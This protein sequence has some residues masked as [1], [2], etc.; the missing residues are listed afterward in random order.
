MHFP[1]GT[2]YS[3]ALSPDIASDRVNAFGDTIFLQ[4]RE[5]G[6]L[7]GRESVVIGGQLYGAELASQVHD[8]NTREAS[9]D[10]CACLMQ[11]LE[12]A[13]ESVAEAD[14]ARFDDGEIGPRWAAAAKAAIA[15]ARR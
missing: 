8:R 2:R 4:H 9:A 5:D 11:A 1:P 7:T 14:R 13:R 12:D 10:L 15:R 3:N 6:T